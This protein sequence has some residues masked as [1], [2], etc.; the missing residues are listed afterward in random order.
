MRPGVVIFAFTQIPFAAPANAQTFWLSRQFLG[1]IE[2]HSI[3]NVPITSNVSTAGGLVHN[4]ANDCELHVPGT[5]ATG[6][7]TPRAV[8][9]EPPNVCQF[10]VPTVCGTQWR[11]FFRNNVGGRQCDIAGFIRFYAEHWSNASGA[12]TRAI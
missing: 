7:F 10:E 11:S 9:V 8:V 12:R 2:Q 1:Q 6:M 5:A 3:L 4:L